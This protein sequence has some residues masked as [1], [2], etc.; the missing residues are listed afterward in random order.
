[1]TTVSAKQRVTKSR[2]CIVC[3][4]HPDEKPGTGERCWGVCF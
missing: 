1:M 3:E 4:S 2:P